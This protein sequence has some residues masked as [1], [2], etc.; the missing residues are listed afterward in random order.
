MNRR[1]ALVAIVSVLCSALIV[2]A[3]RSSSSGNKTPTAAASPTAVAS[4][5]A[6]PA[7][8]RTP[9]GEIR[10]VDLQAVADV[11]QALA[12]TGGQFEQVRVIY[13]DLTG[14][15]QEDAV[16]PIASGGTLGDLAFLVLAPAAGGGTTTLLRVTPKEGRGLAVAVEGGKL[17]MTE[18]VPGPDDPECCPS[19][20]RKTTYAWN[21]TALVVDSVKTEANPAGGAKRT[22]SGQLPANV[23][24]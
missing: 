14:G 11:K 5:A 4:A 12:D 24:P 2:G 3:C 15:G 18:P 21:G 17:V 23:V 6:S 9:S 8:A 20:L 22:P 19:Q 16:I 1:P 13:A 7:P 10:A